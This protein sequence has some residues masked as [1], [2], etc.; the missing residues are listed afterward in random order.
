MYGR[1]HPQPMKASFAFALCLLFITC[2]A[3]KQGIKGQ[4]YWI[5]GNQMPRPGAKTS[6]QLGV[7]REV[8]IYELTYLIDCKQEDGF[9]ISIPTRLV[10]HA[11]TLPDG[12]FKIKLPPGS[13]SVFVKEPKGLFANLFDKNNALNPILIKEKQY[14]WLTIA[15]DYEAA[16]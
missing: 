15:I 11:F 5:S 3:Q 1:N 9:F 16:Y 14:S 8:Y 12:T 10:I 7:Q 4:V 13:Y 6:P 2:S